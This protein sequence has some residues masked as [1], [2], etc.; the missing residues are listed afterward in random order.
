MERKATMSNPSYPQSDLSLSFVI[1]GA[2]GD[3]AHKKIF[4][5]LFALYCQDFLPPRFNV[6]GFSRSSLTPEEYRESIMRYLTCRYTPGESC[7]EQMEA[8]LQRC[9]YVS[10]R[11]DST[12]SYLE[13]Y[14]A[15]RVQEGDGPANRV[16]YMAIPPFLF[17]DVA[18]ALGD[19]GLVN[20]GEEAPGFSRVVIEKP[21][22]HDRE[23]SD[24]LVANT[25]LIFSE[26]QTYR[27]DHYLGKEVIQNLIVLRFANRV[28]EPIWNH[29]HIESVQIAFKE[30][31][32]VEG[33]AGYFDQYG[34]IRDIL[35]NHLLQIA[36]LLA[37]EQPLELTAQAIRDEKVRVLR[38]AHPLHAADFLLGQ[39][40]AGGD[41]GKS[42][43]GYTDDSEIPDDSITPTFARVALRIENERWHGVPFILSAGKALDARCTE[44]R[45]RFR[46]VTPNIFQTGAEPLPANE[47]L[48]RVQPDQAIHLQFLNKVPVPQMQI[49]E[50]SLNLRYEAAFQ[51]TL[52]E[53]YESLL[54]DVLRGDKSLFIRKDELEIAWDLF[55]PALHEIEAQ[56]QKP[57]LY[58]YGSAGPRPL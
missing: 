38:Q 26:S 33:R 5:A 15:M 32:G 56:R 8:F 23:S 4:P 7:Q 45:I 24:D 22:G 3:L 36:A 37:M 35:Q 51:G 40:T 44:I 42:L 31:F 43:P 10:G 41:S 48:I 2:S 28:F 54:L 30:D 13:L 29:Q 1:L 50:C 39:Y 20:C 11:Y 19:S 34:I 18:R 46:P 57:Q 12:D 16:F 21:F 6:F 14:Q 58:P 25:A 17:L 47:L 55:T 53:A 9:F 52:P 27:I 49:A